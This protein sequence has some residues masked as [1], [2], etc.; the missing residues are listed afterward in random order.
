MTPNKLISCLYQISSTVGFLLLLVACH[1]TSNPPTNTEN[2]DSTKETPGPSPNP[3]ELPEPSLGIPG[4]QGSQTTSRFKLTELSA[5]SNPSINIK[6]DII[7]FGIQDKVQV[8]FDAISLKVKSHCIFNTAEGKEQV[9]I[10]NYERKLTPSIPIIEIVPAEVLLHKGIGYPTC[11]FSFKAENKAGSAHHFEWPQLPIMDY[12]EGRSFSVITQNEYTTDPVVHLFIDR[13]PNY[14]L[15]IGIESHVQK[16][17]FVC[18]DFSLS[19]PIHQLQFIPLIAFPFDSVSSEMIQK[20]KSQNPYQDCRIFGYSNQTLVGVSDFF[21]LVYL[22][23]QSVSISKENNRDWELNGD[24]FRLELVNSDGTKKNNNE[25]NVLL[26]SIQISNDNLY[27]VYIFIKKKAKDK[28]IESYSFY[29]GGQI[30]GGRNSRSWIH[31]TVYR[32]DSLS[33][34]LNK[35]EITSGQATIERTKDGTFITMSPRSTIVVP[36]ILDKNSSLC[37][38]DISDTDEF[39]VHWLGTF[40]EY[41]D[42]NI[43]QMVS[44]KIPATSQQNI[45]QKINTTDFMDPYLYIFSHK[46]LLNHSEMDKL[47]H[48]LFIEGNCFSGPHSGGYNGPVLNV[49]RDGNM[50]TDYQKGYWEARWLNMYFSEEDYQK[51]NNTIYNTLRR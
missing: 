26:Y 12:R 38:I 28:K 14:I 19:L 8:P 24:A 21:K 41:V 40:F 11:G 30:V 20:I 32:D 35:L 2:T 51:M 27:P 39:Y 15:K 47:Q 31:N 16:L 37:A 6:E 25:L 46:N 50:S 22:T 10:R 17:N 29:Q 18:D 4:T 3:V 5:V 13:L 42:L 49:Y 9:L 33:F 7:F 1:N 45:V 43:F 48:L 36:V 34:N 23:Q 44:N